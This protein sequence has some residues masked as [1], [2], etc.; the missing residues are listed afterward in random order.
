MDNK[1]SA[2][3]MLRDILLTPRENRD[4]NRWESIVKKLNHKT[5]AHNYYARTKLKTFNL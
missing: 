3:K 2:E 1:S 4:V 5:S